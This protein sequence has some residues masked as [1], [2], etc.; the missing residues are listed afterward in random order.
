MSIR[1]GLSLSKYAHSSSCGFIRSR[2]ASELLLI[3]NGLIAREVLSDKDRA[4]SPHDG[5]LRGGLIARLVA[6]NKP[7]TMLSQLAWT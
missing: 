6:S 4:S 3:S 2:S 1:A 5:L 7:D